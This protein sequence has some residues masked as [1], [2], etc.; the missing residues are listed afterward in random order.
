MCLLRRT[1]WAFIRN[2]FSYSKGGTITL[3]DFASLVSHVQTDFMPEGRSVRRIHKMHELHSF[4]T[5]STPA[6]QQ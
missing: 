6:R 4:V 5:L 3:H 1:I 2:N